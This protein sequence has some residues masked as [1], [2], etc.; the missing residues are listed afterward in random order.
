MDTI[1][2]VDNI[3]KPQ[4]LEQ[5]LDYFHAQHHQEIQEKLLLLELLP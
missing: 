4:L 2:L 1:Q 5:T 3:H